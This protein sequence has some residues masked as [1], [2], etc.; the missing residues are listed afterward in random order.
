MIIVLF[1]IM[2]IY[3]EQITACIL[4]MDG[5]VTDTARLHAAAWKRMFDEFL[6][7]RPEQAAA[8][9][10]PFDPDQDY[11]EYVDGKPRYD[12]V[13]SFLKSRNISLPRGS[14]DDPPARD[15]ITGLG[16][17]KNGYFLDLLAK[18]EVRPYEATV[19]FIHRGRAVGIR[20]AL[21]SA[22]RNARRVLEAAGLADLFAVVVDGR[23]AN[24][25]N[26]AGKP[27][28]DIFLEAARRL[29]TVAGQT[30]V[31]EDALAGVRAGKAGGFALVIGIDRSKRGAA[32]DRAGADLIVKDLDEITFADPSGERTRQL[33]SA[34]DRAEDIFKRLQQTAPAIFLDY[35]GTL[36]PIVEDPARARLDEKTRRTIQRLA[37]NL[38]VAVISGRKLDE[39]RELVALDDLVYA[40][41][42]GFEVSGGAGY[43][44]GGRDP[45]PFL[46]ALEKAAR[47]LDTFCT[48]LNGVTVERKPFAVT[49]HYRGADE[50]AI[51]PLE[52][53]V[54]RIAAQHKELTKT[55]GKMIFELR[56]AVDW[57]KGRAL[58]A[59]LEHFHVDCARITPLYIG[60]DTTD[61]DA[62]RRISENGIP[63]LV[64]ER[65]R[66]TTARFQLRDPDEVR[67]FLE[68]LSAWTGRE[69]TRGIWILDYAGFDPAGEKLREAICSLG[70]GYFASRGAAPESTAGDVHYPGTYVAGCYNR[71]QSSVAGEV[72]ENESL[73]NAPNWLPLSVRGENGPWIDIGRAGQ[74]NFRQELD[75]AAGI[76]TRTARFTDAEQREFRLV[77]R[78]FVSMDTAHVAG[79]ETEIT[80]LNWTGTLEVRS[81]LD[82]G[83]TNSLVAR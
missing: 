35:D 66:P 72:I 9:L 61:E 24:R 53:Q 30:V 51:G 82:G 26:L 73:V 8:E 38:F 40:G 17:R 63:I 3:P 69:M 75:M 49:V 46:G 80:A 25:L 27:A 13:A 4:D 6:T 34:L 52:S 70:N 12:G 60:D 11:R 55:A 78:R 74:E 33:P 44:N 47:E 50:E 23:T 2:E 67:L 28:P 43:F 5:V 81:G 7:T 32:M 1:L 83:V 31:V 29:A 57:D 77:E 68:R 37:E 21:V 64:S 48:E 16:N 71:L 59:I 22:S 58:E 45:K 19:D 15:T 54:D 14:P 18:E 42:H 39:I 65:P 10:R 56:P 62:F 36:T 20:F 76:L 41:S 79:L